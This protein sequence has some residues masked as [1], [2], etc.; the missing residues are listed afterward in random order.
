[1]WWSNFNAGLYKH[2]RQWYSV[3][4]VGDLFPAE[5]IKHHP[6][7]GWGR[8]YGEPQYMENA[9]EPEID[10]ARLPEGEFYEKLLQIADRF[11]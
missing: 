6:T 2:Y 10:L 9:V 11:S 8:S 5:Y 4:R 3:S 7:T 1:M